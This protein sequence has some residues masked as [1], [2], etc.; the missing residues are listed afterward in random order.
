MDPEI[1]QMQSPVY[2]TRDF[3]AF[4]QNVET[5]Q[6]ATTE[7]RSGLFLTTQ[8]DQFVNRRRVFAGLRLDATSKIL[9][10]IVDIV[11]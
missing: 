10:E 4:Y 3:V 9:V 6:I 5:A 2:N 1:S 8:F 11:E 7:C